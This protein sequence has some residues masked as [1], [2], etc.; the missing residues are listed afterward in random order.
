MITSDSFKALHQELAAAGCFEAPTA[1]SWAKFGLALGLSMAIVVPVYMAAS[2]WA[3]LAL[4]PASVLLCTAIMVGHE[5]AHGAACEK[6]WQNELLVSV[7]F[8]IVSGVSTTFWKYKHNVLHHGNPNVPDKDRDLNLGPVVMAK[9]QYDRMP[10]P[11]QWFQRNLQG[12]ALWPLTAFLAPLMRVR[13]FT[14]LYEH[15]RDGKA[16]RGWAIDLAGV[17]AH[18]V[19]WLVIPSFFVGFGWA[20]AVYLVL[21][22]GVGAMLSYIFLLGH[23][24]LP[25]A[26]DWDDRWSL[27]VHTTRTVKMGPIGRWFWVGLDAQLAHHLFPKISHLNLPKAEAPIRAW[28]A[29]HGLEPLEQDVWTATADVVRHVFTSWKDEP[30]DLRR[31]VEQATAK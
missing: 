7:A 5:G 19:A 27:Q 16:D 15:L 4:V 20:L 2:W 10:A 1:R 18:Y 26:S 23:T 14:V 29:R 3:L 11:L 31:A 25:L 24:G 30:V 22:A 13:S 9:F 17:L 12:F 28:C 8:G 6:P 21:F